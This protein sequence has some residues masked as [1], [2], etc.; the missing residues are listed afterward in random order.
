MPPNTD[1]LPGLIKI[2]QILQFQWWH[3]RIGC[4]LGVLGCRFDSLARHSGLRIQHCHSGLGGPFG[5]D[6]S[7]KSIRH[8]EGWPKK[9]KRKE[10][11]SNSLN[12]EFCSE[13]IL[14]LVGVG[15]VLKFRG[16]LISPFLGLPPLI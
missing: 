9:Q 16:R 2:H 6:L 5:L 10:N 14:E 8:A 4:V 13:F 7:G 11:L 1:E 15:L 12:S 3:N